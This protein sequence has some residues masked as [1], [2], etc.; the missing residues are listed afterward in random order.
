MTRIAIGAAVG[1]VLALVVSLAM[2]TRYVAAA[3]VQF[4]A[5]SGL[6]AVPSARVAAL[7]RPPT[8]GELDVLSSQLASSLGLRQAAVRAALAYSS[9]P[10]IQ[11]YYFATT[12][13]PV[14]TGTFTV[15]WP[16]S[17]ASLVLAGRAARSFATR[18]DAGIMTS[19]LPAPVALGQT[20]VPAVRQRSPRRVRDTVLG[21]LAGALAMAAWVLARRTWAALEA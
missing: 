12:L 13:A 5:P 6:P 16:T 4:P 18:R 1:G 19:G 8:P 14:A 15:T 7:Q 11:P 10:A 20:A 3:S 17:A 21:L 2:P 9:A